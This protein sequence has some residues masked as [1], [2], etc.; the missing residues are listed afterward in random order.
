A[1]R[2]DADVVEYHPMG[3]AWSTI[4]SRVLL[5]YPGSFG[6]AGYK[7]P[8]GRRSWRF[9]ALVPLGFVVSGIVFVLALVMSLGDMDEEANNHLMVLRKPAA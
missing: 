8:G 5:Q 2:L 3:G 7:H 1:E 4:A 9:W 6:V